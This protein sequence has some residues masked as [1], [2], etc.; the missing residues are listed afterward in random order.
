MDK[1]DGIFDRDFFKIEMPEPYSLVFNRIKEFADKNRFGKIHI[2][3][4]PERKKRTTGKKSQNKH[5]NGHIQTICEYTGED[6]RII[7]D[8]VKELALKR[9]YPQKQDIFGN[10]HPISETECDTVECGMLIEAVHEMADFMDIPL[11]EGEGKNRWGDEETEESMDGISGDSAGDEVQDEAGDP[12]G[13]GSSLPDISEREDIEII[14]SDV[15][16]VQQIG[17][18]DQPEI[19]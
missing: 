6:F 8:Y 4:E 5:L 16:E 15:G 1:I 7:K 12:S 13:D 18:P 3:I 9:G 19:W 14:S 2:V 11:V 17:N 10:F